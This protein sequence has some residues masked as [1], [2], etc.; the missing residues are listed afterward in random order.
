M[1]VQ[2]LSRHSVADSL[3][4]KTAHW[5]EIP[6]TLS[7][8]HPKWLRAEVFDF[9]IR[10]PYNK[11]GV[12][13]KPSRLCSKERTIVGERLRYDLKETD[14]SPVGL[15]IRSLGPGKDGGVGEE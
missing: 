8:A 15:L 10:L 13:S 6:C 3:A 7:E 14:K 5:S 2:M 1:T 9:H 12:K 11:E 4:V